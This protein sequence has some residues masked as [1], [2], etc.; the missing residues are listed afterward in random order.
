MFL[1][2]LVYAVFLRP[3]CRS[4]VALWFSGFSDEPVSTASVFRSTL[5]V[6]LNE[7]DCV[8]ER[9]KYCGRSD[10]TFSGILLDSG[11]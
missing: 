8:E 6:T 2:G 3:P 7:I 10:K 9:H 11:F 4:T 1:T 5:F